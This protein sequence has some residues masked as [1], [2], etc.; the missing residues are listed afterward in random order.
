MTVEGHTEV[1]KL[2]IDKKAGICQVINN[3]ATSLFVSCANGYTGLA[4]LHIDKKASID[5]AAND[6][7]DLILFLRLRL[8]TNKTKLLRSSPAA[9]Y[10]FCV[11]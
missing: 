8:F 10:N 9:T 5:Q 2:L 4:G 1:T 3:G 7:H 6:G 11:T